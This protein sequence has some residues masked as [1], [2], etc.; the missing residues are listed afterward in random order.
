MCRL[1][2]ALRVTRHQR[3]TPSPPSKPNSSREAATQAS[4]APNVTRPK[5]GDA[6]CPRVI[7]RCSRNEKHELMLIQN[8]NIKRRWPTFIVILLGAG[9]LLFAYSSRAV[10][11]QA[12]SAPPVR[13]DEDYSKFSH[14]SDSHSRLACASCHVRADNSATPR[15]PGHKAC[16]DC[17]L[18][19]FIT[20]KIPLCNICHSSLSGSNP[21][22]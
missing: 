6:P 12:L 18:A 3:T 16:T 8:A 5:W 22:L 7:A 1:H 19:E 17:H 21:P 11:R 13:A 9:L 2:P 4:S 15:F 10:D 20:P 14:K